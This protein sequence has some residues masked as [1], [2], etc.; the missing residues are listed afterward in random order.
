MAIRVLLGVILGLVGLVTLP[1]LRLLP[2][3]GGE[4]WARLSI[5]AVG[6]SVLMPNPHSHN[7]HG[8]HGAFAVYL[9]LKV[10]LD[11]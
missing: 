11:C 9:A 10:S 4:D 2:L 6:G 1:F 3:A 7:V 8:K 5:L